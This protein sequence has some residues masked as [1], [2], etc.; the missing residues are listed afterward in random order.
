MRNIWVLILVHFSLSSVVAA[1]MPAIAGAKFGMTQEGLLANGY[2]TR[3]D[4]Q[5]F[6]KLTRD[7]IFVS[8]SLSRSETSPPQVSRISVS[9]AFPLSKQSRCVSF[10]QDIAMLFYVASE[11]AYQ[12]G[13]E[14]KTIMG[15]ALPDFGGAIINHNFDI[16]NQNIEGHYYCKG[17]K[18][19]GKLDTYMANFI[20]ERVDLRNRGTLLEL[21]EKVR[22]NPD[23]QGLLD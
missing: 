3:D 13:I 9:K 23:L 1:E 2:Q 8:V 15:S 16:K 5:F 22:Q 14:P 7:D 19:D 20:A 4:R 6:F 21:K 17:V 11:G 10:V 12:D 18:K